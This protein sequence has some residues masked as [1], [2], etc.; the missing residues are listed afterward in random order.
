MGALCGKTNQVKLVLFVSIEK[1]TKSGIIC[2]VTKPFILPRFQ[3]QNFIF[4]PGTEPGHMDE[5][6]TVPTYLETYT[7]FERDMK[8][9]PKLL[10][11]DIVSKQVAF[12]LTGAR[13]EWRV[14]QS[15]LSAQC[16]SISFIEPDGN[17]VLVFGANIVTNE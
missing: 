11:V 2:R 9:L 13:F 10:A 8:N 15:E 7:V 5:E 1:Y 16:N 17:E 4:L 6:P 14:M 12:Q 3:T